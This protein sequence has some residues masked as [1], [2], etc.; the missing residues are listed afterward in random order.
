MSFVGEQLSIKIP[1]EAKSNAKWKKI[2]QESVLFKL[3]E[4]LSFLPLCAST[5]LKR[6]NLGVRSARIAPYATA[7]DTT[8]KTVLRDLS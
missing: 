5:F 8:V 4:S 1:S 3:F 6:F 2:F 7:L